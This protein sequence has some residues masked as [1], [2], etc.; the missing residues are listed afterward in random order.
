MDCSQTK[1]IRGSCSSGYVSRNRIFDP[2]WFHP[3]RA[4]STRPNT[5]RSEA[6]STKQREILNQFKGCYIRFPTCFWAR[7]VIRFQ[8]I[9]SSTTAR[10][11]TG[12]GIPEQDWLGGGAE[13]GG[14][15]AIYIL[16]NTAIET[17][18][19]EIRK[20]AF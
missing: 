7:Q 12:Q 5:S 8:L 10:V 13:E 14:G 3:S 17:Q 18:A 15:K 9:L 11:R 1:E 20:Q 19:S 2:Y 4:P 16:R 6:M